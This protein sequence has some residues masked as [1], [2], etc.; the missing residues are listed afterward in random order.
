MKFIKLVQTV[1]APFGT[2]WTVI[3]EMDGITFSRRLWPVSNGKP[4][5]V[6]LGQLLK[7][8]VTFYG[9]D[10]VLQHVR[11]NPNWVKGEFCA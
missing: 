6:K 11:E 7:G 9:L 2:V 1:D 10:G 5:P 8:I 4:N 3:L